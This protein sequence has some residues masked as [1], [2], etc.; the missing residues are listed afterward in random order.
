MVGALRVGIADSGG[1]RM[2]KREPLDRPFLVFVVIVAIC[3]VALAY[4]LY[5]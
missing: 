4:V 5:P 1:N 2:D 3:L